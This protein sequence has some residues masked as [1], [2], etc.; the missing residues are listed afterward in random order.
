MKLG[1]Y[2]IAPEPISTVYF[3]I[4]SHQSV[5][6]SVY[7]RIIARQLLGKHIPAATNTCNNSRT[8]GLIF[9]MV[10]VVLKERVCVSVCVPPN[11]WSE[12][13]Q[14]RQTVK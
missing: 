10:H 9:F 7:P 11:W 12:G 4:P 3:I 5:C 13:S 1:I 14:S 6:L 8:V 2:I